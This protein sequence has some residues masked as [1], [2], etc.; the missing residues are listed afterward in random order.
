MNGTLP[1]MTCL[2]CGVKL[3]ERKVIFKYLDF[4]ISTVLPVCPVCSQPYLSEEFVTGRLAEAERAL[5]D[6]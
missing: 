4:P 1:D 6:K 5:E 2:K 3:T